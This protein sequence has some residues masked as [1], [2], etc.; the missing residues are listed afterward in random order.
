MIEWW[1]IVNWFD[2]NKYHKDDISI[3]K[4]LFEIRWFY[5]IEDIRCN[6]L[7]DYGRE[8]INNIEMWYNNNGRKQRKRKKEEQYKWRK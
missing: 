4:Y 7:V 6:L 8:W 2:I 3:C 1:L 5:T